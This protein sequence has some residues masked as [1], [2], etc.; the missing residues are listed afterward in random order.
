[1]QQTSRDIW[2]VEINLTPHLGNSASPTQT[3]PNRTTR[4]WLRPRG[5]GASKRYTKRIRNVS[6]L[7]RF[8]IA[9]ARN[10]SAARGERLARWR[11]RELKMYPSAREPART[12]SAQ[13]FQQ[14]HGVHE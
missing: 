2:V 8:P 1:M 12:S 10:D 6:R 14:L 13:G 9:D 11:E 4:H 5:Q 7:I 3:K